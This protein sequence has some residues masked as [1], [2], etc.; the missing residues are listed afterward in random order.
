MMR[1][2]P[3]LQQILEQSLAG[4]VLGVIVFYTYAFFVIAPYSGF[5]W[6]SDGQVEE[7]FVPSPLQIGDVMLQIGP[8]TMPE[9]YLDIRQSIFLGLQPG[10]LIS[11]RF[12]RDGLTQTIQY[13][14]PGYNLAEFLRRLSGQWWLAFVFWFFGLI[15]LL[16]LRPK[17]TRWRL[18]LAFNFLMAFC[19][20]TSTASEHHLLE[21]AV[22]LRMGIWLS[23]PV[24]LHLHWVLPR[25]VASLPKI[26]WPVLHLGGVAFA[27]AELLQ[28]PHPGLYSIGFTFAVFGSVLI[29]LGR[30]IFKKG[31]R[32]QSSLLLLAAMLALLPSALTSMKLLAETGVYPLFFLP[33]L[34]AAYLYSAYHRQLSG[35]EIR[36]N[37][38]VSL[39]LFLLVSG[40]GM[41]L[42]IPL[43][44]DFL[45]I[46]TGILF[47][48]VF[49]NLLIVVVVIF[50]YKP[51]QHFVE[52]RLLHIPMSR[53]EMLENFP[54]QIA[55]SPDTATLIRL[56]QREILPSLLI[57]QSLLL[58]CRDELLV[59]IDAVGV[60][61]ESIPYYPDL[62]TL[63][64]LKQERLS[65]NDHNSHPFYG[66]IR[67]VLPLAV[68]Q[69]V[70]G[71]W[72]LGRRDPD[73]DYSPNDVAA[74]QALASQMA[75][76]LNHITQTDH[77]H[78]LYQ[79]N[80]DRRENERADL[81]RELHDNV[82]NQMAVLK[83]E[84]DK[85]S[86]STDFLQH[87]DDTIL[88]LREV[89]SGLRP[90]ILN[91]GL[92]V[93]LKAL[94][95]DLNDRTNENPLLVLDI[96]ESDIR[97]DLQ[98]EQHLYRIVQQACENALQHAR[99]NTIRLHGQL[100]PGRVSL[101][102]E[103]DGV[104]FEPGQQLDLNGWLANKHYGVAGM[105]ERAAL[106]SANLQI[107]ST[108]QRGARV[109]ILWAHNN[110]R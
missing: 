16:A 23:L 92:Y 34:P 45:N 66:W 38:L 100:E 64:S 68:G 76:A 72:V 71:V 8:L 57:H 27:L 74:L 18:F 19:F 87:W 86:L 94:V 40:L 22:L 48:G 2:S 91:Y 59:V 52:K 44:D 82:L 78:A 60:P 95:D 80:I 69:K 43:A 93:A 99:A 24:Y 58:D 30:V 7:I 33:I 110:H 67:L 88:N 84:F 4:L 103:D 104:G 17:D 13:K 101:M 85:I 63:L 25:P 21:S 54:G 96:P 41:M 37:R 46:P 50:T 6:N 51:F 62:P 31:Q 108:P 70:V 39:Y 75:I 11:I 53:T 61:P 5:H 81:A 65:A 26:V 56:V 35:L 105:F 42:L 109:Q 12:Q 14:F 102:I 10:D 3:R 97:Y 98:M 49:F 36:G 20:A 90:A 28:L 47:V 77:L 83:M 32:K 55:A 29:L 9:I 73:D 107:Y 79:A 106:V 1:L 89:V 15:T